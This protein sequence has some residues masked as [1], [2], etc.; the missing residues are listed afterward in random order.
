MNASN[1]NNRNIAYSLAAAFFALTMVSLLTGG[2][3]GLLAATISAL[4]DD[5]VTGMPIAMLGSGMVFSSLVLLIPLYLSVHTIFSEEDSRLFGWHVD[6]RIVL[7]LL[8][9]LWAGSLTLGYYSP[10]LAPADWLLLPLAN[11]GAVAFPIILFTRLALH[12]L[13]WN[14]IRRGWNT[15]GLG[16]TLGPLVIIIAELMVVAF[17]MG[18]GLLYLGLTPGMAEQMTNWAAQ[19]E[20]TSELEFFNQFIRWLFSPMTLFGVISFMSV[21]VPAIEEALKPIG[22]W[23]TGGRL[24]STTDG[25]V[26][27]VL[28][29]AGF[30][31]FES[32]GASAGAGGDAA[33]WLELVVGRS[34]TSLLHIFNCGLVGWGL[35]GAFQERK[36][37]RLGLLFTAS[38]LIHGLWNTASI[39]HG[40][41]TIQ[42]F[43]AY[44]PSYLKTGIPFEYILVGLV[45]IMLAGLVAINIHL[46]PA[47]TD[48][49]IEYNSAPPA[50]SDNPDGDTT[51][52]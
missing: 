52:A 5:I 10:D 45:L 9:G 23:L 21:I 16:M 15:L 28:S 17:L 31:L 43:K 27:G 42:E 11:L 14:S 3:V 24:L 34:G 26:L 8:T 29:G 51:T 20:Q 18:L 38:I 13:P 12:K 36:Y 4:E 46:Q 2:L 19:M 49:A 41:L 39:L 40:L 1:P 25:F 47:A 50:E 37:I 6:D 7:P 44:I 22:V 35:A 32:L 33:A 30:S 48:E